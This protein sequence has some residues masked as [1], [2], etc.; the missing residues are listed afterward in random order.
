V[1]TDTVLA[2]LSRALPQFNAWVFGM[3]LKVGA[4]LLA[5]W[6]SL[7]LILLLIQQW[8]GKTTLNLPAAVK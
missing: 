1:L 7:P 5:L 6:I 2:L 3:P 4:G 8:L